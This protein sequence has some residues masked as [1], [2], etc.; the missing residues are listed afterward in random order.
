MDCSNAFIAEHAHDWPV[1][2]LYVSG[3]YLNTTEDGVLKVSSPSAMFYRAG[4]A[5]ANQIGGH[6]FDQIQIEFDP[7]WLG[8]QGDTIG[9]PHAF[10]GGVVG[11]AAGRLARGWLGPTPDIAR[12]REETT[13]FIRFALAAP[14]SNE[15]EWLPAAVDRLRSSSPPSTAQLADELRLSTTWVSEAY[16]EAVGE[17]PART[18]IRLRSERA[19]RLL[20]ETDQPAA[21]I[22][23]DCGFCDQSHMIRTF[24]QIFGCSPHALRRAWRAA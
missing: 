21:E 7:A 11:R 23:A 15:P 24:N 1:L 9:R 19:A 17:G 5:H 20:R 22:A 10:I 16:R 2:S 8:L 3:E 12:L 4:D 18:V 14:P 13:R 6:G